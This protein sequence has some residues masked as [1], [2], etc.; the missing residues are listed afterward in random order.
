MEVSPQ[1]KQWERLQELPKAFNTAKGWPD[2][3]DQSILE[4]RESQLTS[5]PRPSIPH[6]ANRQVKMLAQWPSA[7][8]ARQPLPWASGVLPNG[9]LV[10]VS[11]F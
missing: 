8:A 5:A 10:I 1:G 9:T 3:I 6:L 4:A 2:S 11:I 7:A